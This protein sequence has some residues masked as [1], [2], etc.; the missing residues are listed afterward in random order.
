FYNALPLY[1]GM[2]MKSGTIGGAKAYAGYHT[3]K[4]GTEYT[5]AIIINNYD[6]DAGSIV[7]KMFKVL[8]ELK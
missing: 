5:F 8:D 1:N 3:S 2:K 6:S 4:S 7:P